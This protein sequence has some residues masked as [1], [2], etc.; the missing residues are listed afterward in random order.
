MSE[1]QIMMI[2]HGFKIRKKSDVEVFIN[3]CMCKGD[4]YIITDTGTQYIFK[5]YKNEIS[6]C[7]RIGNLYDP[8]NPSLEVASTKNNVYEKTVADY[9]WQNRKYINAK[10]FGKER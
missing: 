9:V 10:W 2:P 7:E 8:F 1:V 3:E 5:K 4:Y 6:V